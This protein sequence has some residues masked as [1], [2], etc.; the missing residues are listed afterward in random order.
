M[1]HASAHYRLY[2][3]QAPHLQDLLFFQKNNSW[4]VVA[5]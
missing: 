4:A 1:L 5:Y 3:K 2:M